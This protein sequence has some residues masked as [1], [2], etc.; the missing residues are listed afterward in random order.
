MQSN[1]GIR[2][3]P[4]FE[5][6]SSSN[7]L[8]KI[9]ARVVHEFQPQSD[10]NHQLLESHKL[11][12]SVEEEDFEFVSMSR[13]DET[14]Y[15]N[16]MRPTYPL[17]N[18]ALFNNYEDVQLNLN[19]PSL[20]KHFNKEECDQDLLSSSSD[21]DADELDRVPSEM[22]CIWKPKKAMMS[23]ESCRKSS[24]TGS[25]KS[26][27]FRHIFFRSNRE[28]KQ[29]FVFSTSFKNKTGTTKIKKEGMKDVNAGA[30]EVPRALEYG[31]I[32][33]KVKESDGRRML[34]PCLKDIVGMLANANNVSRNLLPF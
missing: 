12:D 11:P 8:G 18:T 16:Q 2:Q 14:M 20:W 27:K 6:Y 23:P 3:S 31:A 32:N 30:S 26:W 25:S 13:E 22:Y 17:F 15:G 7:K 1:S 19:S 5:T 24:S 28:S 21:D 4:S 9:A 34:V 29:S 33:G 10:L